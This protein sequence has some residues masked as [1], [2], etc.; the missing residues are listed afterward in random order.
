[1][2]FV[3]TQEKTSREQQKGKDLKII[4]STIIYERLTYAIITEFHFPS[5][6]H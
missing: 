5:H 3:E 1:M 6:V 2:L 4:I